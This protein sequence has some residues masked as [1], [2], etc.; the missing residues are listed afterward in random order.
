MK[1]FLKLK[2]IRVG[3]LM[4]VL[5]TLS[6][7]GIYSFTGA[8]TG[9]AETFQVRHFQNDADL[10]EPGIDRTFTLQLQDLIENQTSLGLT[11]NN[12]DLV[13]E[14]EITQFYIAPMTSTKQNTAAENRLTV[15]VNVRF[16][17]RDDSE[18]DFEKQFSYYYDYPGQQQL[19]GP[20]LDTALE[21]IFEHIT[22]EIFNDALTNW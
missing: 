7:C 22:Q 21:E 17:N 1:I 5:L 15:A 2:F 8:D 19:T 11:N 20:I 18:K 6:A 10:V 12:G 13:F 3:A 4:I 16:S 9:N 14:G